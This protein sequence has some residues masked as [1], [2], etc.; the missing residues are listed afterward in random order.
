MYRGKEDFNSHFKIEAP[1]APS[2]MDSWKRT[3]TPSWT[4]HVES[5]RKGAEVFIPILAKRYAKRDEVA[6]RKYNCRISG[7]VKSRYNYMVGFF[8][9]EMALE[10]TQQRGNRKGM[11][12][13]NISVKQRQGQGW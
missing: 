12:M 2:T 7:R 8:E 1:G 9:N 5:K 6:F 3:S 10:R 4:K 13:S 11:L